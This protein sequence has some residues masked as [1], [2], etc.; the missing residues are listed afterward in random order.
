[1]PRSLDWMHFIGVS[2]RSR[3][4]PR[5]ADSEVPVLLPRAIPRQLRLIAGALRRLRGETVER[6]LLCRDGARTISRVV[7][8]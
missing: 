2:T 3:W 5:Q 1:M 7:A 6:A 4:G 8:S